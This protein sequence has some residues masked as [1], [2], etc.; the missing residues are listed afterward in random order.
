M[1]FSS[2]S[3]VQEGSIGRIRLFNKII[4]P[5]LG[6]SLIATQNKIVKLLNEM[7]P[8]LSQVWWRHIHGA[9]HASCRVNA[10]YAYCSLTL[11][12]A[13][14]T[15]RDLEDVPKVAIVIE[16]PMEKKSIEHRMSGV[17]IHLHGE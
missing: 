2:L 17:A 1:N 6:Q 14:Q 7:W 8:P 5:I 4:L 9:S 12:V 13:L 16:Y 15:L 10:S 3:H 11:Q